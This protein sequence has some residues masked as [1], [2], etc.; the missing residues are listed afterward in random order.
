[1][2]TR[3]LWAP[4]REAYITGVRQPSKLKGCLFCRKG[5]SRLNRGDQV[6]VRGPST[7]SLLNRFPY[8]NGHM[9]VAP[10]RHVARI[11]DLSEE[12][13]LD[14]WRLADDAMRRLDRAVSPHGY[15]LGINLG[16]AAGAGIPDHLHLH[17]VPRWVGDTNFMPV[18]GHTKVIS[19][20]LE[21]AYR[22]LKRARP[23]SR[24]G[25]RLRGRGRRR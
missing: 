21:A 6:L 17:I 23:S 4:W 13:W 3:R 20:S 1:M 7:F 15:N 10:Y 12:E 19:Q 25:G 9:L 16:R 5:R 2:S 14:L 24:A 8:N 18:L 11:Q 22:I